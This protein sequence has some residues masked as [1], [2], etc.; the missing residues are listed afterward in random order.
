MNP[1]VARRSP[2][3]AYLRRNWHPYR[4]KRVHGRT[5]VVEAKIALRCVRTVPASGRMARNHG[6]GPTRLRADPSVGLMCSGGAT[7]RSG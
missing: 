4:S 3:E 1:R 7:R 2:V 6:V 5:E